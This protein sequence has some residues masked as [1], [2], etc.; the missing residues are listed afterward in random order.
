MLG[1]KLNNYRNLNTSS[2]SLFA[3]PWKR[4]VI[5]VF[6]YRHLASHVSYMGIFITVISKGITR[7]HAARFSFVHIHLKNVLYYILCLLGFLILLLYIA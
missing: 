7:I 3:Q 4:N 6:T 5:N 2:W 1:P